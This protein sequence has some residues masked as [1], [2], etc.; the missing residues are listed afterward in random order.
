MLRLFMLAPV[1]PLFA[2]AL[3][4]SVLVTPLASAQSPEAAL[5]DTLTNKSAATE[6]PRIH[7]DPLGRIT[8]LGAPPQSAFLPATKG[9]MQAVAESFLKTHAAA[10]GLPEDSELESGPLQ[11]RGDLHAARFAQVLGGVPVFGAAV[12]VQLDAAG[13]IRAVLNDTAQAAPK[14]GYAP[15]LS[16]EEAIEKAK[17]YAARTHNGQPGAPAGEPELVI[18]APAVLDLPGDTRLAWMVTLRGI[19]PEFYCDRVFVDAMDGRILFDYPLIHTALNR[20]V[21]DAANQDVDPGT[22]AR[23]E[24]AGPSAIADVN[25]AYNVFG[26]TYNFYSTEH[27]RDSIDDQGMIVDAT[28]RY[29]FIECP[30][31]NAHWDGDASRMRF[32]SGFAADDVVAHEYTHG[33][34]Q[35]TSGLIYAGQ[36]GALNESLSDIWGEFVDLTNGRGNDSPEVRWLVGEDV[37]GGA[38]RSM[39]LPGTFGHPG[40]T[41]G[42]LYYTG[43]GDNGGV[44]INSGVTNKLVYLLT[45]GTTFN[46]ETIVGMGIPAV[47]DLIY[48][49]QTMFLT[50]GS[51]F[52]DFYAG[53]T[54][55]AI[56]LGMSEGDRANIEAAAR[57]VKIT[58]A[59]NC[60]LP[61]VNDTCDNA[62]PISVD[63]PVAGSTVD[64][65]G[66]LQIVCADNPLEESAD[67][68]Y[69]FTAPYTANFTVSL[70]DLTDYDATLS[71]FT[72]SC[73]T[74]ALAHCNDDGCG[75]GGGPATITARFTFRETYL[76][77][78]S[79]W[80]GAVGSYTLGITSDEG[81]LEIEGEGAAHSLDGNA[82]GVVSLSELL[83]A[84]QLFNALAHSCAANPGDTEDGYQ[85]GPGDQSCP[86]HD[87]D[88]RP[89]DWRITL[90][91]LLRGIQ[92]YNAGSYHPCPDADPPTEDGY[93]PHV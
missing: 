21:H 82:N 83:R 4:C 56:N 52:A 74:G 48:E 66:N 45:D 3:C 36:S 87:M 29:C 84:I 71:I 26:D 65:T 19:A 22:L 62:I 25:A 33:V 24:G 92:L 57:A 81:S 49:V 14:F 44:H 41:C 51:N 20:R 47:A 64:A 43:S 54:Q 40:T 18:F 38:I 77:R 80:G 28:M 86:A 23:Q 75:E 46:D 17:P 89:L 93:C 72:G 73:D 5:L 69:A 60:R 7:R 88:Y 70:C 85:P 8:F 68:W 30:W 9:A 59:T 6:A 10:F 61:P 15:E 39:S 13:Q 2:A 16:P 58:P 90:T 34:T 50:P 79:G 12:A 53:L 35:Y 42:S 27:G 67:V 11:S 78:V 1:R 91:E 55:A 76:V 31:E 37:A 63:A 32:G